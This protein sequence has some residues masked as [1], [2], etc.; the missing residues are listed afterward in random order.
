MS[1]K[2]FHVIDDAHVVLCSRGVYRQAKLYRR[3]RELFA[4]WGSGYVRLL[5]ASGTTAPA[6]SWRDIVAPD[7]VHEIDPFGVPRPL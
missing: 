7:G 6:V 2:L 5:S 3:G 1:D 4:G